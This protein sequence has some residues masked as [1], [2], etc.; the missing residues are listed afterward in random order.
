MSSA[1]APP[2]VHYPESDGQPMGET[3]IHV[4]TTIEL[5]ETFK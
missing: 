1:Q 2:D 4:N 3:G 5:F